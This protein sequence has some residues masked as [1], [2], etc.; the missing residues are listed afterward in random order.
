MNTGPF[1]TR[2]D[3]HIMETESGQSFSKHADL[4]TSY[5]F[6]SKKIETIF[7]DFKRSKQ[8]KQGAVALNI[9]TSGR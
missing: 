2:L 8:S 4:I 6:K 7:A 1:T 9:A 3:L 5:R